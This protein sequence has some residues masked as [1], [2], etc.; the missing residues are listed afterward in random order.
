[1]I[2]RIHL[3]F[4]LLLQLLLVEGEFI[5]FQD[6]SIT[7]SSL[8]R[9]GRDAGQQTTGVELFFKGGIELLG[10]GTASDLGFDVT[11]SLL[12]FGLFGFL[13]TEMDTVLLLVPH[14]EGVGIDLEEILI[15]N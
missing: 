15:E 3:S 9:T 14:H 10:G 8:T 1:M 11:G 6:V 12:F 7:S 4:F 2:Q 13:L 5:T